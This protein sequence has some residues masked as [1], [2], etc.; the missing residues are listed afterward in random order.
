MDI[1]ERLRKNCGCNIDSTPCG[2]E[3][4][5]RNVWE[6]ANRIELL[7]QA[8]VDI[9]DHEC[10]RNSDRSYIAIVASDALW[11]KTPVGEE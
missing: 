4:E 2:A 6:A 10:R 9:F 8:L 5:C 3:D 11:P 7:E 1:V